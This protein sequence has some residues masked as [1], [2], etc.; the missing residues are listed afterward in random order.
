ME[1]GCAACHR[2]GRTGNDGPG[3]PLTHVGSHLTRTRIA[4]ALINATLRCPRSAT[5][6]RAKLTV[7]VAYPHGLQ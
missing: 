6:P 2:V 5:S 4:V 1:S 7:L 3:P